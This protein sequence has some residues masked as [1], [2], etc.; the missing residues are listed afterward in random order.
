MKIEEPMLVLME[1][2]SE[3]V[4]A[5]SKCCR[6]GLDNHKPGKPKTNREHLEEELGDLIAMVDILKEN[7]IVSEEKIEQARR[8]KVDKLKLWSTIYQ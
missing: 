1:E 4:Q 2:C 3:V 6:F 7:E 8:A 5:I